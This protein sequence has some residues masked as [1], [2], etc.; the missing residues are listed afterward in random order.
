MTKIAPI[1]YERSFFFLRAKARCINRYRSDVSPISMLSIEA[2]WRASNLCV[3][4]LCFICVT[5]GV[6]GDMKK[7][8]D[9]LRSNLDVETVAEQ[10]A[11]AVSE[12]QDSTAPRLSD[13]DLSQIAG[14]NLTLWRLS[15]AYPTC[16]TQN[17]GSQD[18]CLSIW[19]GWR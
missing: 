14:E 16:R 13:D 2:A 15:S 7:F 3:P 6:F 11:A 4:N 1:K 18:A 8:F 19:G 5:I 10:A 9:E 17:G 12:Q